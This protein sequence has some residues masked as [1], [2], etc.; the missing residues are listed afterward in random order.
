[1]DKRQL[2]A[3]LLTGK[4]SLQQVKADF[5]NQ[6]FNEKVSDAALSYICYFSEDKLSE[7]IL[8]LIHYG[9]VNEALALTVE[10]LPMMEQAVIELKARPDFGQWYINYLNE[11]QELRKL[12]RE[13]LL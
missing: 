2:A 5:A 8:W 6:Y 4:K 12:E 1:M 9:K 11:F 7:D 10:H 3:D 13:G